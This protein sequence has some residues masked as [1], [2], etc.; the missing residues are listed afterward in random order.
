[1]SGGL[2]WLIIFGY[3]QGPTETYARLLAMKIMEWM[4]AAGVGVDVG[5]GTGR[6]IISAIATSTS[7]ITKPTPATH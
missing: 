1:M 7:K 6:L 3:W 2:R 5:G 4:A